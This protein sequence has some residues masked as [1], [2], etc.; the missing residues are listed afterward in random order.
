[1]QICSQSSSTIRR[2]F[3]DFRTKA[4]IDRE[5]KAALESGV[6]TSF[7]QR[8]ME[9]FSE[10]FSAPVVMEPGLKEKRMVQIEQWL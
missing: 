1:M 2:E 5:M 8:F 9:E 6:P 3:R 10:E 4:P 7:R